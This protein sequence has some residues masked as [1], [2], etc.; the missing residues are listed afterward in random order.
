MPHPTELPQL[1]LHNCRDLFRY[2]NKY[3]YL[4][5][6]VILIGRVT[7]NCECK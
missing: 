3:F 1:K 7:V 6:E 2:Y 5:N 4:A